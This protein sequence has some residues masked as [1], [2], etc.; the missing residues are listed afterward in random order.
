MTKIKCAVVGVGY[1]GKFHA[2]KYARLESAKLI[3]VCDN[4]LRQAQEVATKCNCNAEAF[5]DYNKLIG[6]VDA[7]SIATPTTLHYE[8]AKVFLE[9][10]IHVLLEKPITVTIEEAKKLIT[11]AKKNQLVFQIGHLERFNPVLLALKPLLH[12]PLVI[13]CSRLA[14]FKVRGSDVNV[15]MDLM[16]HDIDIVL[17]LVNSPIKNI[18]AI[19]TPF[20]SKQID[21]ANARLEFKNGC[22][23][24]LTASRVNPK[25]IRE[26]HIIQSNA[27][28]SGD[29][30]NKVLT[31]NRPGKD[32]ENPDV[33]AIESEELVLEKGDALLDEIVA[34]VDSI[35][36]QKP[37]VISGEDGKK[38]LEIAIEITKIAANNLRHAMK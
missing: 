5:D 29:L 24:N 33:P 9:N 35:S 22:V 3:A 12:N 26:I 16:I 13:E 32:K 18:Q 4:N 27:I 21:I 34:F 37:P 15:I 36:K 38:A 8:V 17:S 31:I 20:L 19:G 6:K 11:I 14:T 30:N 7:V 10:G 1:L 28:F 23:A 25:P 2:E